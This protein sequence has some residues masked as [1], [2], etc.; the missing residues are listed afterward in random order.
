MA[1]FAVKGQEEQA[2]IYDMSL[3]ELMN[4]EIVSA[5]KKAESLFDAPLSSYTITKED[6]LRAGSMSIPDALRLCP[7]IIV[8][9]HSNGA[10]D[11]HLR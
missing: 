11:V 3:E 5:S 6:I 1:A 2:D 4:I 10:Y 7:G 9:E 8:R